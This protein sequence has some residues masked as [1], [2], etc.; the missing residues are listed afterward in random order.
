MEYGFSKKLA[1]QAAKFMMEA[2]AEK[3][4]KKWEKSLGSLKKFYKLIKEE[5]KLTLEPSM[6]ASLQIKF[7]KE[8]GKKGTTQ[9]AVESE[10]TARQFHAEVYRMSVFQATKTAHLRVLA[11]V[12]K[13][14]AEKGHGNYHW[15]KA[16]DYLE[17]YYTALKERVA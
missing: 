5:V 3:N 11:N 12:E 6:A 13:N 1:K 10:E 17:K 9:Q 2:V 15:D 7:W 8:I 14:L 16:E 4:N